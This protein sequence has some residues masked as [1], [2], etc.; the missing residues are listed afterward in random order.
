MKRLISASAALLLSSAVTALAGAEPTPK[1]VFFAPA[2]QL[3]YSFKDLDGYHGVI[4]GAG[5]V[6]TVHLGS[7]YLCADSWSFTP[8]YGP[9]NQTIVGHKHLYDPKIHD[10][11]YEPGAYG[12]ETM[13]YTEEQL[14]AQ[15]GF[16][17]SED[18]N[19]ATL[20]DH[21]CASKWTFTESAPPA[22]V[23]VISVLDDKH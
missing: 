21:W 6:N 2:G 22:S 5:N 20:Q 18:V 16:T 13:C 11:D 4:H 23:V 8:T 14:D 7:G 3:C 12:D 1:A 10:Y 9:V 15:K 17:V 19:D